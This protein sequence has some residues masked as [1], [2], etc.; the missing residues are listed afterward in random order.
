[1]TV[2]GR[3]GPVRKARRVRSIVGLV[4]A[5]AAI[6]APPAAA[7]I[8]VG[9]PVAA[10]G[11]AVRFSVLVPG[12][13]APHRTREVVLKVPVGVLPYSFGSTPG[14]QRTTQAKRGAVAT[15]TW[16]G[17]AEPDGFVEFSFLAATPARTGSIAWKALQV[18]DD[19][20]VVRWIGGP[21]SED[22]A[23]LTTITADAP[24]QNAGGEGTDAGGAGEPGAP[25]ASAEPTGGGSD[26]LDRGLAIIALV[27]AGAALGLALRRRPVGRRAG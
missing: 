2:A 17:M 21:G 13:R 9:P 14:W 6:L 15:I 10:P 19:G 27:I 24:L 22:P 20:E 8:Q 18:Y 7:H 26:S 12:E 1:M 4:A 3:A 23:P 25:A 16:R 11:D 5:L